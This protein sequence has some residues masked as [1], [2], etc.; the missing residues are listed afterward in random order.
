LFT[1]GLNE[2]VAVISIA[3]S[4]CGMQWSIALLCSLHFISLTCLGPHTYT[5]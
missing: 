1:Y 4:T 2:S 5:F 3:Y